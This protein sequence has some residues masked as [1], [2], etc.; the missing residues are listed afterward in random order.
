[1]LCSLMSILQLLHYKYYNNSSK[2]AHSHTNETFSGAAVRLNNKHLRFFHFLLV[3]TEFFLTLFM[4]HIVN[5]KNKN[6][7]ITFPRI[8]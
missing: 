3:A 5:S 7:G 4:Q 2:H 8:L 1:M 6:G